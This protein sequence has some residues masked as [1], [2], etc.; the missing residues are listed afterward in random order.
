MFRSPKLLIGMVGEAPLLLAF[1]VPFD[2][3]EVVDSS[4]DVPWEIGTIEG[5]MSWE[6]AHGT[7]RSFDCPFAPFCWPGT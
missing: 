5:G 4:G 6:E 1:E 7:C 2:V 3:A